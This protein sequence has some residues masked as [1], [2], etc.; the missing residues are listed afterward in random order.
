[1]G[2]NILEREVPV[3]ESHTFVETFQQQFHGRGGLFAVRALE[4]AVLHDRDGR[5]IRPQRVV[6]VADGERE[7]E[8]GTLSHR[9]V[10]RAFAY[11]AHTEAKRTTLKGGQNVQYSR[12]NRTCSKW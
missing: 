10:R 1:M 8:I 7:M 5:V 9:D 6:D 11:S 12:R 2:M 3:D 4:V